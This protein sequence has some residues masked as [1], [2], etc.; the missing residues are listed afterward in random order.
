MPNYIYQCEQKHRHDVTHSINDRPAILCPLCH[1]PMNRVPAT[2]T[3]TFKGS[4]FYTTD[5]NA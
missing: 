5:K 2:I 3:A 1:S 4:G